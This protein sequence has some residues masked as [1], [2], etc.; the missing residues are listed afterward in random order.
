MLRHLLAAPLYKAANLQMPPASIEVLK[1]SKALL[2]TLRPL[3][4]LAP[5]V[6]EALIELRREVDL[7]LNVSPNGC[8]V[9]SMG[10]V[11]TPSI[12]Q[13]ADIKS[14]RIQNLFSADGDVNQELLTMA[15][16]KAMGPERYY[17]I[18]PALTS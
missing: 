16:L 10:E 15:V 2:P 18:K 17:Q 1:A 3:G 12:M 13:A 4:E 14:G 11:L 5:Y 8:M 6:G 9:S 7:F